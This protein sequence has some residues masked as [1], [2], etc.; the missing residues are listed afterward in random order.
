MLTKNV[1]NSESGILEAGIPL[2]SHRNWGGGH[3]KGAH[4]PR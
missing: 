3:S 1:K 2:L 4:F